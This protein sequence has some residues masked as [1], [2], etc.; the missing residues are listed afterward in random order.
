MPEQA[1]RKGFLMRTGLYVS[2]ASPVHMIQALF[3]NQ[4]CTIYDLEDS[5][6][7]GEKDAARFLVFNMLKHHRPKDKHVQIRVNGLHTPF[8]AED[9]EAAVR[10]RP[11]AIRVPK[12]ESADE[13]HAICKRLDELEAAAGVDQGGIK[14]WCLIESPIGVL[15]ARAIAEADARVEALILGAEDFTAAMHATRT[16]S[17]RE[18]FYARNMVLM[19]CRAAGKGCIDVVFSDIDDL[20][21]LA[22]DARMGKTL[23]FDGKTVIH[24]RQVDTVNAAFTPTPKEIR[25]AMRVLDAAR[26]AERGNKAAVSLDGVMIDTPVMLRARNVIALAGAAG[27]KP[28]GDS[29]DL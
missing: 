1:A 7:Q 22:E 6:P 20:E 5:V 18:V 3:H 10:A 14:I 15:N 9:M 11:D 21:G 29:Y 4:D 12:V 27:L 16:K 26:E 17:G 8:F 2:G 13:V 19:A 25:H 23:G 24:P 28:E